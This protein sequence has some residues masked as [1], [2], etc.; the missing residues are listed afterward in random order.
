MEERRFRE[1]FGA[2]MEIIVHLWEMMEKV[3]YE[4]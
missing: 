4:D 2:R 1:L 3:E